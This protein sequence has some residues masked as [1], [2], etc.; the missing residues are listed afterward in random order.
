MWPPDGNWRNDQYG[1]RDPAV[2]TAP[3]HIPW[4]SDHAE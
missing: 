3:R 4:F 1:P 2:S